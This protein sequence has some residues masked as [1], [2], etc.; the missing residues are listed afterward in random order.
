MPTGFTSTQPSVSL[1]RRFLSP[2][3]AISVIGLGAV[4]GLLLMRFDIA[5]G[6]TWDIVRTLDV[7]W[8]L[9]AFLVHY[10][11]F[12]FRGARWRLLLQNAS[13]RDGGPVPS[14]AYAGRVILMSWFA[15]SVTW[16]RMGDAYRAF[17][18]AEDTRTSF[19]RSM[20]TV[21]AD[22]LVDLIV[23]VAL[24]LAGV[25]ILLIGGQ[26]APPVLLLALA[27]TLL[28]AIAAGLL[29]MVFAGRWITPRLPRR[30]GDL[31]QRFHDGTMGSFGRPH[32][33]LALGIMA[34]LCEVGR[35]FFVVM[36]VGTPIALGL[37]LFVPMA[38]GLLSAI[39]LTPGG[40]GIVE[41]GIA[42]LLRL[43]LS[44][45]A[46]LAVAL[47]DRTISYLS[48]IVFGG[49]IFIARQLGRARRGGMLI[50][51]GQDD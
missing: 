17:A 8:Y 19:P 28:V 51:G 14:V 27:G 18:Y 45:E 12:I 21:V 2:Q 39:P 20:G 25:I 34:W 26:I 37:V 43:E 15:N 4:L 48:T 11:T 33:V 50:N 22:R 13:R 16:F 35:L 23:V 30:I 7:R 36:A 47:V 10:L 29:G 49:A 9:L 44:V 38:N 40:L 32:L 6:D 5:W 46:A 3:T 1:K 41:A 24:M 42:G 31:Y